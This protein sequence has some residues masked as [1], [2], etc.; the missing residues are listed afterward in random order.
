M[1]NNV[2][3][4]LS[5]SGLILGFLACSILMFSNK[6]HKHAN[7]LLAVSLF[8]LVIVMLTT[9]LLK[10]DVDIYA[11]I[12][13]FPSPLSYLILPTAYLYIRSVIYDET[14]L[15]K[16]DII[17][18]LPAL[19]HL[20]E[21]VPHYFSTYEYRKQLAR[22]ILENPDRLIQ[23][24]E[25][26]LPPYYHTILRGIQGV[27]YI[28]LMVNLLK[29]GSTIKVEG[30]NIS[31]T[32]SYKWMKAFTFLI[33]I[34]SI[35]MLVIFIMPASVLQDK[36]SLLLIV[37]TLIFL[38][39]NLYLFLQPEILYGIPRRQNA[40]SLPVQMA[41]PGF[42]T[43]KEFLEIDDNKSEKLNLE[44]NMQRAEFSNLEAYKPVLDLYMSSSKPFLKQKYSINDLSKDTGIPQHHLSA[45]LN[46]IYKMRFNEYL[47]GLRINY[48]IENFENPSWDKLTLEGIAKQ[49]GFTSRTTFFYTIKKTT[50]QTPS[51][52]IAKIKEDRS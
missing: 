2:L 4:V 15:K 7:H 27:L 22:K 5:L 33:S 26:L 6:T 20:I 10:W 41:D 23:I 31:S 12:Y 44:V 19:L 45:L 37:V 49:V 1:I 28:I 18:F 40:S 36:I 38:T 43:K 8:C 25:G 13:R 51:E 29:K 39:I 11:Y 24:D 9:F 14:K 21:M 48:I 42:Q 30:L 17:H 52:F 50:G 16:S 46:R 34:I 3:Q 35:P 47:N 32:H